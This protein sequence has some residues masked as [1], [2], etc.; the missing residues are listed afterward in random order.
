MLRR[1]ALVRT[2]VSEELSAS[3]IRVTRI[4]EL[5]T[6]LGV[7]TDRSYAH[8]VFLRSVRRL[9]VTASVVPSSPILVTLMMQ[10]L[11]SSETSV[12]TRATQSNIPEDVILHSYRR[13]NLK[14]YIA[15]TGWAL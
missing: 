13:E 4:G 1:V 11:S 9:L 15:L 3:F 6:T 8:I 2:D 7:T 12:L 10:L 5:G 14:S